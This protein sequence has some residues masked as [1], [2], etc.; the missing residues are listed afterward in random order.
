MASDHPNATIRNMVQYPITAADVVSLLQQLATQF[1]AEHQNGDTRPSLL[2]TAAAVVTA[3]DEAIK[4]SATLT[5]A[6]AK[7]S[8]AMNSQNPTAQP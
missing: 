3:A 4:S 1:A 7:L 5:D 6:A 8:S 2:L